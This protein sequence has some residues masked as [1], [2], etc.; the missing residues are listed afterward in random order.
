MSLLLAGSEQYEF[1][2]TDLAAVDRQKTPWVVAAGHRPMYVSS[3]N[4]NPDDGD[5]TVAVD[6]QEALESVFVKYKVSVV[7]LRM[8]HCL[9]WVVRQ[10]QGASPSCMQPPLRCMR[11]CGPGSELQTFCAGLCHHRLANQKQVVAEGS[12]QWM[13][14]DWAECTGHRA[15]LVAGHAAVAAAKLAEFPPLSPLACMPQC[16]WT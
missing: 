3:D 8:S 4:M 9:G 15:D 6:L 2:V 1:I 12:L 16:R 14:V 11:Q 13:G 10:V 7:L 5:L